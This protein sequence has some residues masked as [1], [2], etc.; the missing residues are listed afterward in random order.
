MIAPRLSRRRTLSILAATSGLLGLGGKL[1]D[2]LVSEW[3]GTALGA[4]GRMLLA[5]MAR[6]R[7]REAI[8]MALAEVDRLEAVFSL[9]RPDSE[10][11]RLN[12]E[13]HID[14]PSQDLRLLTGRALRYW[15]K[16]GG[17]FNPA[18]QPVWAFLAR[19]FAVSPATEPDARRLAEVA[20]LANPARVSLGADQITLAPGMALTLN[21]IAQ[22]YIT[23]R[24]AD[25]LRE[26]GFADV[27]VDLGE[28]RALP[29]RRWTIGIEGE[30]ENIDITD[31]ALATS[32]AAGTRFTADG[33][34]HHLIDPESGRSAN[35][36]RSVTVCAA[37]ACEADAL[38]TAFFIA[39]PTGFARL[40]G[41]FPGIAVKAI[42]ADGSRLTTPVG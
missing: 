40:A 24:V 1:P 13:G 30:P 23:D 17:V 37:N 8:A 6:A 42:G 26:A 39:G 11:S 19:H 2:D 4:D 15:M 32:A 28:F 29:G 27:L 38:A 34:W 25:L 41:R 5:G 35:G 22:G 20:G 33:R 36:L 16:T 18:V 3:R 10:L 31:C 9:Y 21:G 7:S 12:A 14:G